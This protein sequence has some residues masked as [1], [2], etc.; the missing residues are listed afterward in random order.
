MTAPVMQ[1]AAHLSPCGTFRYWL[2]RQWTDG[3]TRLPIIML[4]PSTA[5]AENDDPTIRRCIALARREGFGGIHVFNLFAFRATSPDDMKAV[6]DPVGP[7][8]DYWLGQALRAAAIARVPVL[9]A[10][11]AH[12][13]H[14]TRAN[15]VR[16]MAQLHGAELVCLGT[17]AAGHPRHPL[18][19]KGDQPLV[20]MSWSA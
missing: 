6:A 19:V 16:G 1:S 4:N 14:R 11:G 9:A 3:A 13:G 8:N 2:A 20:A 5:D 17:T 12:G 7:L 18:Y 10:W 15:Y